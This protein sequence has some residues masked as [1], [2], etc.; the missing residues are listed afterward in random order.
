MSRT[1]IFYKAKPKAHI[2]YI[3]KETSIQR[4]R[5]PCQC[6]V[7][8]VK[9]TFRYLVTLA[10]IQDTPAREVA[11]SHSSCILSFDLIGEHQN[12]RFYVTEIIFSFMFADGFSR[13][14]K[15]E[16]RAEKTGCSRRLSFGLPL[17]IG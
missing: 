8:V 7:I 9:F 6:L 1:T 12:K 13:R 3:A 11:R 2:T 4:R 14:V 10:K 17:R 5:K 15:L 16:T